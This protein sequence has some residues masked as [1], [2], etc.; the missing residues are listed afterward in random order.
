MVFALVLSSANLVWV[1]AEA[2][3]SVETLLRDALAATCTNLYLGGAGGGGG[4]TTRASITFFLMLS[5]ASYCPG[6]TYGFNKATLHQVQTALPFNTPPYDNSRAC[7]SRR[8]HPT[9][10]H[11]LLTKT[12][13]S[14]MYICVRLSVTTKG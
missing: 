1:Y 14:T 3:Q 9:T 4:N 13:S 11:T 8:C 7:F 2:V 10:L 5:K 6:V 12:C